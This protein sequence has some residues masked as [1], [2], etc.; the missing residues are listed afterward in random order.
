MRSGRVFS[1]IVDVKTVLREA[2]GE[3][4]EALVFELHANGTVRLYLSRIDL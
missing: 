4:D 1:D 2:T 3:S